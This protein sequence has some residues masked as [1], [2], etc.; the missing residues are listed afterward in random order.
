M[1]SESRLLS[2]EKE[3]TCALTGIV[4]ATRMRR[5]KSNYSTLCREVMNALW[6]KINEMREEHKIRHN[7]FWEDQ[8]AWQA[9]NQEERRLR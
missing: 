6:Q 1:H 2:I 5:I 3:N 8:K 7:Q 9:Q 4:L